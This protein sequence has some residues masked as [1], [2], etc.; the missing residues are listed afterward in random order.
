MLKVGCWLRQLKSHEAD[1][2]GEWKHWFLSSAS[3][4]AAKQML[5]GIPVAPLVALYGIPQVGKTQLLLNIIGIDSDIELEL[6]EALRGGRPGGKT[7]TATAIIYRRRRD[8]SRSFRLEW[9]NKSED[10]DDLKSLEKAFR[11][12][13]KAV[14]DGNAPI[15][16]LTLWFPGHVFQ[17]SE[18]DSIDFR[19]IDLPGVGGSDA[20]E[21]SHLR[22]IIERYEP[23]IGLY[24]IVTAVHLM[25]KLDGL[26]I[27]GVGKLIDRPSRCMVVFTYSY[28]CAHSLALSDEELGPGCL[29]EHLR[30]QWKKTYR[31][32]VNAGLKLFPVDIGASLA[33]VKGQRRRIIDQ[34]NASV[35][36]KIRRELSDAVTEHAIMQVICDE[37]RQKDFE[38]LRVAA[39]AKLGNEIGSVRD[40]ISVHKKRLSRI[41][42]KAGLVGADIADRKKRKSRL[43]AIAKQ[44]FAYVPHHSM[45]RMPGTTCDSFKKKVG[46]ALE[47]VEDSLNDI[48]A[49]VKEAAELCHDK[50]LV[51]EF[52]SQARSRLVQPRKMCREFLRRLDSYTLNDYYPDLS[53]CYA[54][55][56]GR[57]REIQN[58]FAAALSGASELASELIMRSANQAQGSI[59]EL[60]AE[61]ERVERLADRRRDEAQ[62]VSV[63]ERDLLSQRR[64]LDKHHE[65]DELLVKE[66][67]SQILGFRRLA[68]NRIWKIV[69]QAA[70]SPSKRL[71]ALCFLEM[72]KGKD[73]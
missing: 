37:S 27:K 29:D 65:R 67:R 44:C 34:L 8:E 62:S 57:L 36:A 73:L 32:D 31:K 50:R 15:D 66:I 9:G 72:F 54:D 23:E 11:M 47:A 71:L 19:V 35:F 38:N 64:K 13:R 56:C 10:C 55:D 12:I 30:E 60:S 21:R 4:D 43:S 46:N 25:A 1:Y 53:S 69:R 33:K 14:N 2:F 28:S 16:V 41:S 52:E 17:A 61:R 6:A 39:D 5:A 20:N 48:C 49:L 40:E 59:D 58:S 24:I 63:R 26:E 68:Q 45:G 18:R 51:S 3:T 70:G 42:D 7:S 22:K